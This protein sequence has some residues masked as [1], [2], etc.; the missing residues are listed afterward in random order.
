MSKLFFNYLFPNWINRFIEGIVNKPILIFLLSL[1][2]ES[3]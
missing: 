3:I 2:Q 1:I